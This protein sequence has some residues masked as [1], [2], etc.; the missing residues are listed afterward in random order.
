MTISDTPKL[1]VRTVRVAPAA[2]DNASSQ[3]VRPPGRP[4]QPRVRAG[5][6]I[7]VSGQVGPNPDGSPFI[8]DFHAEVSGAIDAVEAVMKA[9]GSSGVLTSAVSL[10]ADGCGLADALARGTVPWPAPV[11]WPPRVRQLSAALA[12]PAEPGTRVDGCRGLR[13]QTAPAAWPPP[14][15]GLGQ[16]QNPDRHPMFGHGNTRI[17]LDCPLA[18]PWRLLHNGR[19]R[20]RTSDE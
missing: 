6:F 18:E 11:P 2:S 14:W 1:W 15:I 19:N 20:V 7:F 4:A 12:A 5:D 8:G 9:A 10:A 3:Q 16:R 13:Q 17:S